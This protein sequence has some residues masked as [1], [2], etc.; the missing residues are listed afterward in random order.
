M[1]PKGV[2]YLFPTDCPCDYYG[3]DGF[4]MGPICYILRYSWRTAT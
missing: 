2:G 4:I 1:T 3:S